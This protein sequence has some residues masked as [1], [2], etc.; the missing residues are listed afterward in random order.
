MTCSRKDDKTLKIFLLDTDK[1]DLMSHSNCWAVCW[2]VCWASL[3]GPFSNVKIF[4][5]VIGI[6]QSKCD[7]IRRN[8]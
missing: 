8:A 3:C 1:M 6:H 4:H 5:A 2:A 7:V